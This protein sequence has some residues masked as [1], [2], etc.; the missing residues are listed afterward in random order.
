MKKIAT[1]ILSLTLV[2]ALG[3]TASAATIGTGDQDI[4]HSHSQPPVRNSI[5]HFHCT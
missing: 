3:V 2:M 5:T 4:F 1:L